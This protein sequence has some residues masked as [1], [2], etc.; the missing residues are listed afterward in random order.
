MA[1]DKWVTLWA[2]AHCGAAKFSCDYSQRTMCTGVNAPFCAEGIRIRLTNMYGK[3]TARIEG[4]AVAITDG[5]TTKSCAPLS[6]SGQPGA[7]IKPGEWLQS[8]GAVIRLIPLPLP[9]VLTFNSDNVRLT[10]P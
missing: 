9:A 7:A 3:K 4:A 10:A 6:F 8:D 1:L 2:Q 5:T